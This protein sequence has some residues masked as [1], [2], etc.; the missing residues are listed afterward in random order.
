MSFYI[1]FKKRASRRENEIPK[2]FKPPLS[3]PSSPPLIHIHYLRSSFALL[4]SN[5]GDAPSFL[6][7]SLFNTIVRLCEPKELTK[8]KKIMDQLLHIMFKIFSGYLGLTKKTEAFNEIDIGGEASISALWERYQSV[9]EKGLNFVIF[10]SKLYQPTKRD[11]VAEITAAKKEEVRQDKEESKLS[12]GN[13]SSSSRPA[14]EL[15]QRR[16]TRLRAIVARDEFRRKR[17]KA[18]TIVQIS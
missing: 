12:R 6:K 10:S 14:L 11:E 15:P 9:S 2:F 16:S 18:A 7:N 8:T 5:Y 3:S 13:P 17:N 1:F 4:A